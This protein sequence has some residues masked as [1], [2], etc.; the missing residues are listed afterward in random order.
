MMTLN[1][2]LSQEQNCS[3]SCSLYFAR[4]EKLMGLDLSSETPTMANENKK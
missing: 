2:E 3:F 1:E 4:F